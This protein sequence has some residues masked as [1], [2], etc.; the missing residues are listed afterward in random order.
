MNHKI[1][2]TTSPWYGTDQEPSQ[3]LLDIFAD[4]AGVYKLLYRTPP[5]YVSTG[6]MRRVLFANS[7]SREYCVSVSH[8]DLTGIQERG[9]HYMHNAVTPVIALTV[10]ATKPKEAHL[11]WKGKYI[12]RRL[13]NSSSSHNGYVFLADLE[14][15]FHP[16]YP[17]AR[18]IVAMLGKVETYYPCILNGKDEWRPEHSVVR[19]INATVDWAFSMATNHLS[20]L[21]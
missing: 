4:I 19:V 1:R 5:S 15:L 3:Q 18:P 17:Y 21:I 20:L 9:N 16:N 2:L 6:Y 12:P 10:R 13:R 8:L 14:I 7:P 11:A